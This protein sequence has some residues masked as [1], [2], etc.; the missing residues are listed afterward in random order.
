MS[1]K[2]AARKRHF[3]SLL[4]GYKHAPML[5]ASRKG[6]PMQTT[7][8]IDAQKE[9]AARFFAG[10][11]AD[12]HS[13]NFT[14]DLDFSVIDR[15]FLDGLAECGQPKSLGGE[16]ILLP[17]HYIWSANGKTRA[18]MALCEFV[19]YKT[20]LAYEKKAVIEENLGPAEHFEFFPRHGQRRQHQS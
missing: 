11:A 12:R 4:V 13:T 8:P 20:A 16:R 7:E 9:L 2:N 18:P 17:E 6:F 10:P 15:A 3:C 19:A 14:F 5:R 1:F